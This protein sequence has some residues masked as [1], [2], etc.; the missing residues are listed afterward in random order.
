MLITEYVIFIL[1]FT[2]LF[3]VHSPP[4]TFPFDVII[5]D[6]Y[7]VAYIIRCTNSCFISTYIM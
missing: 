1:W 3:S 2:F 4:S 6:K 7:F 5:L